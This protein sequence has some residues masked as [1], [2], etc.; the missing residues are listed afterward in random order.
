[1][2]QGEDSDFYLKKGFRVVAVE[3]VESFCHD[4]AA[5]FA[6]SLAD[7]RLVI[8]NKAIAEKPGPVRFYVNESL[9]IWGT[10][11]SAWADRNARRGAQSREITVEAAPFETL[12]E[13]FGVPYYLKVDIEGTDL[14]CLQALQKSGARPNYV[15]IESTKSSWVGLVSE[16]D[17]FAEMGY[18][19]FKIVNQN[20]VPAQVAPTPAREGKAV[21]HKFG[22]GATGLFG[23]EAP[24]RWLSR[25]EALA[26]YRKI[27]RRYRLF[28]DDGLFRRNRVTRRLMR[29]YGVQEEWY[30]THAAR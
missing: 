27:F 12:L 11:D 19:R 23:E 9:S 16:F 5:R 22:G 13:E 30:D 2:H 3:A 6:D 29:L 25:K 17:L 18:T 10:L 20:L 7:G 24:G 8:V 14:L 1:M 4:A 21:E 15:S 26:E 28:G